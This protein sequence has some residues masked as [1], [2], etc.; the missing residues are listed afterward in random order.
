M[1][2]RIPPSPSLS[3]RIANDTYLM[4]VTMMSVQITSDS[5]PSVAV[6]SGLPPVRPRTVL[7]V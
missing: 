6:G 4:D 2:A 5:A 3:T 7:S 1:S